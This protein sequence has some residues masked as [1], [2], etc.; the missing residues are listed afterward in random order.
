M[1]HRWSLRKPMQASI[2]LALP[3]WEKLQANICDISLGGL[4]ITRPRCPIPV[5]TLATLSFSLNC[6]GVL[7]YHRLSAQ[8]VYNGNNRI[9]FLF[10]EPGREALH[11]L[12]ETL[13]PTTR[14]LSDLIA[15]QPNAA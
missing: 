9:G 1:E 12:R 3:T 4:A 11:T 10:L 15:G 5:N 14:K 8:V 7:S 2:T 13:Y 6:D